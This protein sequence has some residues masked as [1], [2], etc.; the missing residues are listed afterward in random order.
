VCCCGC[1]AA[2]PNACA[3]LAWVE[4]VDWQGFPPSTT[5]STNG[6]ASDGRGADCCASSVWAP[7][8]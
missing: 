1:R 7:V 4:L 2:E 5:T 8:L 6:R 3:R